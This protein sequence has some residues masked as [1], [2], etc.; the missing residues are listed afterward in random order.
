ML[1][2]VAVALSVD[3]TSRPAVGLVFTA[4]WGQQVDSG[5]RSAMSVQSS[6]VMHPINEFGTDEQK[7]KVACNVQ[8]ASCASGLR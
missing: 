3:T 8:R 7:E 4:W 6:L 5:Y 1:H 2:C